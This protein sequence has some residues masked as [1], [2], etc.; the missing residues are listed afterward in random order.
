MG[1]LDSKANVLDRLFAA[2]GERTQ[3]LSLLARVEGL[4]T[5]GYNEEQL[6]DR[7]GRIAYYRLSADTVWREAFSDAA[8]V[9]PHGEWGVLGANT[10]V[11]MGYVFEDGKLPEALSDIRK[12]V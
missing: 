5:E 8:S 1:D 6:A 11:A 10:W 12:P 7:K 3:C 9:S 2:W 4:P